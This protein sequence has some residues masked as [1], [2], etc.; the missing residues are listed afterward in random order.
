MSSN[1]NWGNGYNFNKNAVDNRPKNV[2]AFDT[3]VRTLCKSGYSIKEA[4]AQAHARFRTIKDWVTSEQLQ[5]R[6]G[7]TYLGKFP[8]DSPNKP[9]Q[10]NRSPS[11]Y[12]LFNTS[13]PLSPHSNTRKQSRKLRKSRKSRKSNLRKLK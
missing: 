5:G 8:C 10:L 7:K 11:P 6:S 4:E 13:S 9:I 1:E 2:K 12:S 3:L